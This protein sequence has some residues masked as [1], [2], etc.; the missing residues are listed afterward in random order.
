MSRTSTDGSD[1]VVAN[2]RD[3]SRSFEDLKL[4]KLRSPLPAY[5][6][7]KGMRA[8]ARIE[9]PPFQERQVKNQ[10]KNSRLSDHYW[11]LSAGDGSFSDN[12][13]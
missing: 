4:G 6:P 13:V 9:A 3:N 5:A 1:T 7:T 2:S 10:V 8:M 11:R 12:Y